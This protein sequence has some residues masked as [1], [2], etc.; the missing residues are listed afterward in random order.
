MQHPKM[1]VVDQRWAKICRAGSTS[2]SE[3]MFDADNCI[4]F[5][6]FF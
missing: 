2:I 5:E 1:M 4:H 6:R 3:G